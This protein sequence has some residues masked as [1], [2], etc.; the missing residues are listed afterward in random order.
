[1]PV[2]LIDIFG[3]QDLDKTFLILT[4][5]PLPVWFGMIFFPNMRLVRVTAHPW[6]MVP[7]Y[8]SVLFF[9]LWKCYQG[10]L[11]PDPIEQ[12]SYAAAH[13]LARHPVAFL[14]FYCNFQ[15]M[16]LALGTMLYQKALRSGLRAP[17]ELLLCW[18]L[19]APAFVPFVVR[20]L[21]RRQLSR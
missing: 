19:G 9:L 5:M 3:A 21:I 2:W 18:L 15:I 6:V 12:V 20:L 1:M 8:C 17:V 13:D 7:L 4:L 14:S 11:L 16:N 10:S